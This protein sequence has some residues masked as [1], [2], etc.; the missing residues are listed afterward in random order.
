MASEIDSAPIIEARVLDRLSRIYATGISIKHI[1]EGLKIDK[2]TVKRLLKLL[3][4]S[5]AI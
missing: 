3:G 2:L 1:S 5:S 4:C